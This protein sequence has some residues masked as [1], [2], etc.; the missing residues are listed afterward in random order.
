MIGEAADGVAALQMAAE[1]QPDLILL[2]IE[3]PKLNGIEAAQQIST[4]VPRAKIVFLTSHCSQELVNIAIANGGMG[5]VVKWNAD[6]DLPLAIKAATEGKWFVS[7]RL[8]D[9]DSSD[10]I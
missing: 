9:Y 1:L 10:P 7:S 6:C 8:P 2:D 3:L 5:Y 4:K